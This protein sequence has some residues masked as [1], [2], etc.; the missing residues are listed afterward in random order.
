MKKEMDP[1][2]NLE[3]AGMI[4]HTLL[5]P[6]ATADQIT[7]LCQEALQYQFKSVCINPFWV[8][9]AAMLLKGSKVNVCTVIGFPLGAITT[10]AKAEEVREAVH[11]GATEVD[12]VLN[13]GALKSGQY[14]VALND[15]KG[16]VHAAKRSTVV[17]VILETG[18]LTDG[19]KVKACE[20]CKQA[21]ADFVKT[22][23]GFGPGGA[24]VEDIALMRKTVGEKMGVKASGGV[25]NYETAM[26]MIKAGASRIG[27]SAGIAIVTEHNQSPEGKDYYIS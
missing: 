22:S 11:N 2:F 13:I 25:R 21:G 8:P 14:D 10:A 19:E 1:G 27:A 9:L 20:L 23:T 4:D 17:K 12:M 5:K 3:L 15:I 6:E 26:A 18:L 16:V 7:K 24:N